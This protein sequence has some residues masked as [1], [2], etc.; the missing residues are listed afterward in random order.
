MATSS[1]LLAI[2]AAT[3]PDGS[4]GNAAPAIQAVKSSAAAPSIHFLQAAFDAATD[5]MLYWTFRMPDD[6]ASGPLLKGQYGMA[7]A[8]TG[9]VRFEGRIAAITPG[10]AT[11]KDAKALATTNSVGDTVAATAGYVKEFSI[12]LTNADSL[13]PGDWVTVMLRRDADGT[14]GTDDATG[15]C[16]VGNAALVYTTT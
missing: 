13:A 4:A 16:E 3:P 2:G 9:A 14:T 10:D 7:S 6:Y 11:D 12:T 15:D 1:V 8:T 5:E